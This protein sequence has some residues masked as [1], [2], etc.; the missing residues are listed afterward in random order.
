[1]IGQLYLDSSQLMKKIMHVSKCQQNQQS[2][3]CRGINMALALY[4]SVK[5]CA[6]GAEVLLG[7]WDPALFGTEGIS[8]NA[9]AEEKHTCTLS[10]QDN[11]YTTSLQT[12][13]CNQSPTFKG[14]PLSM[15][16]LMYDIPV[17]LGISVTF[18]INKSLPR[19]EKKRAKTVLMI[20]SKERF[21]SCSTGGHCDST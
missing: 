9:Q 14:F 20:S 4:K 10:K 7:N 2:G 17:I 13:L 21:W 8:S 16:E 6:L 1:M 12:H 18:V 15:T 11:W 19:P 5:Q 3:L